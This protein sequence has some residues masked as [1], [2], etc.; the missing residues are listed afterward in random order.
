MKTAIILGIMSSI[1]IEVS[2]DIIASE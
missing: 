1:L 2:E